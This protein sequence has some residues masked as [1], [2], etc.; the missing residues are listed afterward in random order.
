MK[1]T[2]DYSF[3]KSNHRTYTPVR[4]GGETSSERGFRVTQLP[5]WNRHLLS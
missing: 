3:G 1:L 2:E 4:T 5:H